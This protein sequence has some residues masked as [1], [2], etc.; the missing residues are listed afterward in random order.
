MRKE[1]RVPERFQ[2]LYKRLGSIKV[3]YKVIFFVIGIVSTVWFLIR[4]IPKPSR[5]GY[6]CMKVAAPFMSSF[7]IYLLSISG[8]ALLFK[9]SRQF[10]K[11]T[12]YIMAFMAFMG[13]L[14]LFVFSSNLFSPN[15]NAAPGTTNEDYIGNQPYGDGV[16]VFPG[17]VVWAWDPDATDENC[18]NV[19]DDPVRGEDG[20]FMAKNSDQHVIDGMLK[21]VV[22]DLTGTYSV[23]RAWDSLFINFNKRKGLGAVAYQSGQKIFI[24]INQGGGRWLTNADDLSFKVLNWTEVYYGM[25]ETSP[26]IVISMLDQLVNECGIAEEDIYVGDPI[27][28]IYKHNYDQMVAIFP[29]VKYV[30]KD[31]SDLGRTRIH[32]S[33][34]PVIAWSDKGDVMTSAGIDY[35]YAEMENA[36]YIINIAALKAHARAGITLTTKN[37]FG[38][39]T[40]SSAEHL[41]PGLIAPENDQPIRTEYGVYRV[42]TDVMGHEKLG[43]NTVLF[44]IDGLWG[45][46]EAVEKPVKWN[47]VPFNGDWPNSLIASQD[48]VAL[49]SV[50]FDFLRNEFSDPSGPG[51]AR[52]LMGAVDDYLHQAADSRFWPEGFTYDP[53]GDGTPIGSLGVHEHWNNVNDKQYSRNLGLNYGIE[54]VSTQK[55]LVA[56]TVSAIEAKTVPL[57]DGEA[58]DQ[59]WTDAQW[60]YIDETWIT[61]G[62]EIDA[63]DY[64]GCFKVSWSESEN[65]L[66]YYVEISDDLFVDGYTYPDGDY[67]DFDIVEV[68]LDEDMSG[69]LHVFDDN[70]TW[71]QNSEN[72]F[73]YHIAIDAP[74]DG[75]T[76]TAFHACDIDGTDWPAV[77]MDYA[78][79]FPEMIM[80]KNGNTYQYEFSMK[81]YDDTYD[82]SDPEASRVLL[83]NGKEM[84]MSLAYCDND[85]PGTDRDNF[86]GSVWVPEEAYNDHWMNADGFGHVRLVKS[87]VNVNQPVE[88]LGS[89]ED[90]EITEVGTDLVIHNNLLDVFNDP[91]GD[92]LFYT[93]D[94]ANYNLNFT[95]TENILKVNATELFTGEADV[96]VTATDGEYDASTGFKVTQA[97]TGTE[98]DL[99][100]VEALR[101]FPN[102]FTGLL[103]MELNLKSGYSGQVIVQVYNM[104]GISVMTHTS[105]HISGGQGTL[106]IDLGGEPHGYYI[107]EINAGGTIKSMIINKQ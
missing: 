64:T 15:T 59:C 88:L 11:R 9:R 2:K 38:S 31:H 36:D 43:G 62:E 70:A 29:N 57:I 99:N 95:V 93:I 104:A 55:S 46:T 54:L 30:D 37:H 82:H 90:F 51:K 86:F 45:G 16:G 5:A 76:E 56:S 84:G 96:T 91:D 85:T 53:E 8:S 79:H 102:P 17:R 39:H 42:L 49:E 52:P 26:A 72:A 28:H 89:I 92:V 80:K 35:L 27:A 100:D 12:R 67:P 7:V 34:S 47:S 18:T 71:G 13:A 4:V 1:K 107:L 58:T 75:E 65:L 63:S 21:D 10:F 66:Y 73:S 40:R 41:H 44:L 48:Q 3:P 78:G 77:I 74:A 69:G 101:C 81:I 25:S 60:H 105:G 97:A 68:F 106:S 22:Q 32:E 61:W 6:P 33:S 103:N 83:S 20:Y 24:K 98:A 87:G 19:M 23:E 14:V 94:C 50:C